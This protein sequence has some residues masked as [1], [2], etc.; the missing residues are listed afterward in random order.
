MP[1]LII[2]SSNNGKL[3]ELQMTLSR[4]GFNCTLAEYNEDIAEYV[5][6]QSPDVVIAEVTGYLSGNMTREYIQQ[7]KLR[8]SFPIIALIT[9]EIMEDLDVDQYIDDFISTP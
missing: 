2:I 6:N 1:D 4:K 7:I 9:D 5:S 3:A 8:T